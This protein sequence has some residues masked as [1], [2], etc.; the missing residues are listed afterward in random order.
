MLSY[1][2][3]FYFQGGMVAK[4]VFQEPGFVPGSVT[5]VLTLATPHA[6]AVMMLDPYM[7]S[8]YQKVNSFWEVGDPDRLLV[9]VGGGHRDLLVRSGLTLEGNVSTLVINY[10]KIIF[11]NLFTL[12]ICRVLLFL[13][14]GFRL[15]TSAFCGANNLCFP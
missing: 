11:L 10:T 7:A 9:S 13:Q 2:N 3:T 8:Y 4:G 6:S 12:I 14:S 1:L 5:T 15:T